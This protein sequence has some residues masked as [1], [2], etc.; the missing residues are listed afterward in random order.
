VPFI[1]SPSQRAL[2]YAADARATINH[3]V[4]VPKTTRSHLCIDH[5]LLI[6]AKLDDFPNQTAHLAGLPSL[7]KDPFTVAAISSPF[8]LTQEVIGN[9]ANAA[10]PTTPRSRL[11]AAQLVDTTRRVRGIVP[12]TSIKNF[13]SQPSVASTLYPIRRDTGSESNL[14]CLDYSLPSITA[15]PCELPLPIQPQSVIRLLCFLSQH[16]P[17]APR[18]CSTFPHLNL[19]PLNILL[20]LQQEHSTFTSTMCY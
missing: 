13:W 15:Y 16:P 2:M 1:R 6:Q 3:V 19:Q 20:Q 5:L 17:P 18:Y 9:V 14:H 8:V 10:I 11:S 7:P 4:F 12:A